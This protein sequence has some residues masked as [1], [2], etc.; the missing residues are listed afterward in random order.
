MIQGMQPSSSM[1]KLARSALRL[2][3]GGAVV[4]GCQE[5]LAAPADCPNLCP[6]GYQIRDTVIDALADQD[7][8]YQGYLIAGQGTSLRV[9]YQF[10]V[11]EDRAVLRFVAR[12]SLDSYPVRTDSVLPY[13][14]DSVALAL[15]VVYRD[16]TVHNLR[17][18][19][20]RLPA[21]VD[22]GVTFLD[23]D[24]AFTPAHFIDSLMVDDTLQTV[25]LT[26]MLKDSTLGRVDIPQADSGVLAIGV[27]IRA[28][29]GTGIRL[30][31]TGTASPTFT[32]YVTIPSGDTTV[33]GT[34]FNRSTD[35]QTFVSQSPPPFDT[36]VLTIGG[37]PSARTVIRFPWPAFLKDSAQLVRVSLELSPTGPISGLRGDTAFIQARP[38]LA[39]FGSKSPSSSDAF[40]AATV[41]VVLGQAD[42]VRLEVRRA[43][44]LWQA[45]QP[46]PSAFMLNLIPEASSFTT[47]IFGSTRT[48]GRAPRLRVTYALKFPFEAP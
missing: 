41:P 39:D 25:R 20:Y 2:G 40:Y 44:T 14:V 24:T 21:T 38:L 11:S 17:L 7:S 12:P 13:T 46:T 22:S 4:V 3:L 42:T 30:G 18:M 29:Q 45:T 48:P 28:D 31:S 6:G 8:S 26:S 32:T 5:R 15:S 10:P 33:S 35:F 23:A 19:L 36:S 47:A 1:R 27:Q 16:T 34:P 9:S 43:A 37:I